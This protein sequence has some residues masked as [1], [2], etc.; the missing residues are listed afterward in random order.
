MT[1]EQHADY[2]LWQFE[3][4]SRHAAV[5]YSANDFLQGEEVPWYF[6]VDQATFGPEGSEDDADVYQVWYRDETNPNNRVPV[7]AGV[8]T[9]ISGIREALKHW[10]TIHR[11]SGS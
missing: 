9:L 8:T 1:T 3:S 5:A 7:I 2:L 4:P 6:I 11:N 10:E